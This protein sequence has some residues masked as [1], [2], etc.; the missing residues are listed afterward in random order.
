M[1]RSDTVKK[2]AVVV[3]CCTFG[4]TILA[5]TRIEGPVSLVDA[6]GESR[7]EYVLVTDI[8]G[9]VDCLEVV[10]CKASGIYETR[11]YLDSAMS[12]NDAVT[13]DAVTPI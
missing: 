2:S 13:K 5:G 12:S 4:L 10:G 7:Y 1:K 11:R 6:T 3:A 8:V 9:K